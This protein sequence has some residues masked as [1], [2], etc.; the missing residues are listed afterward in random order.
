MDHEEDELP[1]GA[2]PTTP[3]EGTPVPANS[4]RFLLPMIVAPK[5]MTAGTGELVDPGQGDAA[6]NQP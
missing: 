2:L 6:D 5:T 3:G 1:E 4:S